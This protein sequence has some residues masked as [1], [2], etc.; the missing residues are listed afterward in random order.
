MNC[1]DIWMFQEVSESESEAE[2]PGM[3]TKDVRWY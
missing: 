3:E 2:Q 1:N